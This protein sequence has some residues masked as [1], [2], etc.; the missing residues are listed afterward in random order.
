VAE[1][2]YQIRAIITTV[3]MQFL[4]EDD[5]ESLLLVVVQLN[6]V[7]G[8]L[9]CAREE[10]MPV[11]DVEVPVSALRD[12]NTDD[13]TPVFWSGVKCEGNL[14]C[15]FGRSQLLLFFDTD[16]H[17]RKTEEMRRIVLAFDYS[18]DIGSVV[19]AK[20]DV[21]IIYSPSFH[22]QIR[23]L[24]QSHRAPMQQAVENDNNI[25]GDF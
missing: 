24:D 21:H 3:V 14:S 25:V 9:V 7:S 22:K 8:R 19:F 16:K 13:S 2:K 10:S 23:C 11:R 1:S 20:A 12:D 15:M 6:S 4:V 18:L 17:I 5:E